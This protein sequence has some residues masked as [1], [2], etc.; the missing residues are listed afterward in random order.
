MIQN[1]VKSGRWETENLGALVFDD[2]L[3]LLVPKSRNG[4]STRICRVSFEIDLGGGFASKQ[5]IG[6]CIRI[7][8]IIVWDDPARK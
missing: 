5:V 1:A 6:R 3:L 2:G 4:I 8:I 7:L